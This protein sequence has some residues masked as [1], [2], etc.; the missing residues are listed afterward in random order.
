MGSLLTLLRRRPGFRLLWA[1]DVIS[2]LGDWLSYIAISLLA[3]EQGGGAIAL[4]V[5]FAAHVMPEAAIAPFAGVFADRYER[6]SLLVGARLLQAAIMLGMVAA[7]A[8]NS[9][10]LVQLLLLLRTVVGAFTYPAK[11]AAIGELV[12]EDE[13]VDANALDSTTWSVAFALGTALGGVIAIAGP[14][15]ALALDALTFVAAAVVFSRLPRMDPTAAQSHNFRAELRAAA[16]HALARPELLR[17]VLAKAP[18]A[19]AFAGGWLLLNLSALELEAEWASAALVIGLLQ[20][21]RGVGCGVGPLL[22]RPLVTRGVSASTLLRWSG[23]L[24]LIGVA[25]FALVGS[26]PGMLMAGFVW[27]CGSGGNWVFSCSEIQRLAPREMLGRLSAADQLAFTSTESIVVL[28][29]AVIIESSGSIALGVWFA[30]GL[31]VLLFGALH[32]LGCNR[33]TPAKRASLPT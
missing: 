26:F 10:L 18:I 14:V 13:L 7:A 33:V 27:G 23:G 12:A 32:G 3:L 22:A 8:A 11:N 20:A 17:A 24:S 29:T 21:A 30:I 5:V 4:A 19:A 1:G 28:A 25:A 9:L 2:L 15:L 31:G 6:R 16:G